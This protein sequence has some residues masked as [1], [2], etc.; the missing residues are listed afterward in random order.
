I[1]TDAHFAL[2]ES[3]VLVIPLP[4]GKRGIL[5]VCSALIA[6]EVNINYVYTVWATREQLPCLAI[7]VDDIQGAIRVLVGKKF[8]VLDQSEL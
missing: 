7:R 3:E 2:S 4:D 6:G 8:R 5:T 1:L